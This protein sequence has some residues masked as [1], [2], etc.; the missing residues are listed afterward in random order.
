LGTSVRAVIGI[1][2]WFPVSRRF[3]LD[4]DIIAHY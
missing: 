3:A 1:L 2:V 4:Q